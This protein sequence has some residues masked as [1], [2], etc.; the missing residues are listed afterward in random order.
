MLVKRIGVNWTVKQCNSNYLSKYG[1]SSDSRINPKYLNGNKGIHGK[2]E[3]QG[4]TIVEQGK[5]FLL[6]DLQRKAVIPKFK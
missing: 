1:N 6:G 5:Q 2:L 4:H 3:A